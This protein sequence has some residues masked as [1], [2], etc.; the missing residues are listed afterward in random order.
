MSLL[1]A[2][3]AAVTYAFTYNP[4]FAAIA[5]SIG[6]GVDAALH[7]PDRIGP[8]LNDLSTQ[9]SVYGN[10]I[11]FEYGC[12]RHA[13]TVMWPQT[14]KAVE[15]ET[16]QSAKGGGEQKTFTYTMSFAILVCEGP[17]AGIR[18]VWANKKLVYDVSASNTGATMDPAIGQ[19]RFYL[20]TED[21]EVDPLIEATD[22]ASPAYL[23]YAYVVFEDYDVTEMNGRPP[24]F[25]FEVI[26]S[27]SPEFAEPVNIGDG[28]LMALFSDPVSGATTLH[29]V[30]G[31]TDYI[32][33]PETCELIGEVGFPTGVSS[34]VAADGGLWVGHSESGA[35]YGRCATFLAVQADGT[36]RIGETINF[37]YAGAVSKLATVAYN[38]G[39]HT[40]YGFVNNGLG[41]G[42]I[43]HLGP[44]N[45]ADAGI[46][47]PN[48]VYY[49]VEMP[50]RGQIAVAG[51]GNWL[52]VTSFGGGTPVYNGD[53][54]S[55]VEG[56]RF[57][58]DQVRA[59]IYWA[60]ILNSN[61]YKL[62]LAS[63]TLSRI[64]TTAPLQ[65]MHYDPHTDL[66]YVDN[67]GDLLV[68]GLDG[69]LMETRTG[70]GVLAGQTRGNSVP[71]ND[72]Y[73]FVAESGVV[74]KIPIGGRLAP[75]TVL[76]GDIVSDICQRGGL[77][78]G[79]LNVSQLTDEVIGYPVPHQMAGRAA[80][81]P[82]QQAF[83]FDAVESEDQI[84]F[85]KRGSTVVTTIPA[86][87]RAA[88]EHGQEM[89]ANLQVTRAFQTELPIQCDVQYPD[90]DADHQ[91]GNQYDRRI[92]KDTRQHLTVQLAI[93]MNAVKAKEVART[94]LYQAWQNNTF[95]WTTTRKYAYLE[96]TDIVSLPTDDAT[97]R[98]R[99]T[100]RRDQPNG[101]IQWEG[102]MESAE[103]FTQSG[104]DGV[105]P[106]YASQTI[107]QP[108]TTVLEL[109]D[110]PILRDEDQNKGFYVAMCGTEQSWPGAEV[111][112]SED[113]GSTY[114]SILAF[115]DK[116]AIGTAIS[117]LP[118]FTGGNIFDEGNTVTI[119][120]ARGT[121]LPSYTETQVLN[122]Y[123]VAALGR[124][125][126]WEIIHYK[127]A[128]LIGP[129]TYEL[130]GLLRG[131][132]G[133]EWA[134]S[135]HKVDDSF[136]LGSDV[137]WRIYNPPS[138]DLNQERLYKAPAFRTK[139]SDAASQTFT[140][141]AAR[142]RPYSVANLKA[143]ALNDGG[144]VFSW[145][146]RSLV[147]G[148]WLSGTDVAL[149]GT[150]TTFSITISTVD[151]D[152]S[153]SYTTA[154]E[155]F[156]Y[157][158]GSIT[159]DFG[160]IPPVLKFRVAQKNSDYGDGIGVSIRTDNQ[161]PFYDFSAPGADPYA[162]PPVIDPVQAANPGNPTQTDNTVTGNPW[163]APRLW[164]GT[165]FIAPS[166]YELV[167]D[168]TPSP[169]WLSTDGLTYTAMSPNNLPSGV[170]FDKVCFDGTTYAVATPGE[171]NPY[172][173]HYSTDLTNWTQA[174][175]GAYP[176][177]FP[178]D[179]GD[180]I[181][182]IIKAD[183]R[184]IALRKKGEIMSSTDGA[185]TWQH[186]CCISRPGDLSDALMDPNQTTELFDIAYGGGM[187]V[188]VGMVVK[189]LYYSSSYDGP[190]TS[191]Y[192]N[193]TT[194][195]R[196]A[197]ELQ[198]VE[199]IGGKFYAIGGKRYF[200][201]PPPSTYFV[202]TPVVLRSS[203]GVTWE[204]ISPAPT[205]AADY[206]KGNDALR[207]FSLSSGRLV[208]IGENAD[209]TSDDGGDT[210]TMISRLDPNETGYDPVTRVFKGYISRLLGG[211]TNGTFIAV[212]EEHWRAVKQ[213]LAAGVPPNEVQYVYD[214]YLKP[215]IFD[216]VTYTP[217]LWTPYTP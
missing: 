65:G 163:G 158:P 145:A 183:G 50:D 195:S 101:I 62:D 19:I 48:W 67:G 32:Y 129:N 38:S 194:D 131:C 70:A 172:R 102:A 93:V 197:T 13:G 40:V 61:V 188:A 192:L 82:L 71:Y 140:D 124:D 175:Y 52:L 92:T 202:A 39:D 198:S 51:Y 9:M 17:I 88:H 150:F 180:A 184:F 1:G 5:Y 141:R 138:R 114:N 2:A 12:N 24:Q 72:R 128:T 49:V 135:L 186:D 80:I 45:D 83:Y 4:Q 79:D 15:H 201:A 216:G 185:H 113:E 81:E 8:R 166:V 27:G 7:Q 171:G 59:C 119:V 94:M 18:R 136:I 143:E 73:Y 63:N 149:D 97:Y 6:S 200:F 217:G 191:L 196:V 173:I 37:S 215:L 162:P 213:A 109:M 214:L 157:S 56:H 100:L 206:W 211:A 187:Y 58:Y 23:G 152:V 43:H 199:Y 144:F 161:T 205:L 64:V 96:P 209:Y 11:P 134:M 31:S 84:K 154:D 208:V 85:V 75:N 142:R 98:A 105:T 176:S 193:F 190:Y 68:Y 29:A 168:G 26:T 78:T 22:G 155:F 151:G 112:R 77:T 182:K 203:D 164:N 14:L 95:K 57:C 165:H 170:P 125:G 44:N 110:I 156:V 35:V 127:N 74:W 3:A 21:Q 55:N 169:L 174:V 132:R 104:A 16:T 20:G 159:A 25:E 116:S 167:V 91:I 46:P 10:P 89:P 179:S 36:F 30:Y 123:G 137:A 28:E 34:I 148:E 130:S 181:V 146:H 120:M 207:I 133:T 204:D 54:G 122:G 69:T 111:F 87:D 107:F 121:T 189:N 108:S 90:I 115:S 66:I 147:G 106:P 153:K 53:W 41:S 76:L 118:N 103:V 139:L 160:G 178:N 33:D 210:W 117:L 60:C 99:I 47:A 177:G 42:A 86:V 126:I 212:R